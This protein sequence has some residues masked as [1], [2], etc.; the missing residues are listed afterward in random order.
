M[1]A[2]STS[3]VS[4]FE[5]F[6]EWFLFRFRWIFVIPLILPASVIN[7]T[8]SYVRNLLIFKL[9]SAPRAHDRKV[10]SIQKVVKEWHHGDRKKKMC[11]ARPGMFQN[12]LVK[13]LPMA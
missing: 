12:F 13:V 9:Q 11:T 6:L 3:K 1:S 5:R 8:Y 4:I 10:A 7:D 2:I